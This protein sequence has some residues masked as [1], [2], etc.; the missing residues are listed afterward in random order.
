MRPEGLTAA[1]PQNAPNCALSLRPLQ[2]M[3]CQICSLTWSLAYGRELSDEQDLVMGVCRRRH[4]QAVPQLGATARCW[5]RER[6]RCAIEA[7]HTV[8][9]KG[10]LEE[11][12]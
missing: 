6:R 2:S 9:Y 10:H 5:A 4:N 7:C 12:R 1:E 3:C 8:Q 11:D